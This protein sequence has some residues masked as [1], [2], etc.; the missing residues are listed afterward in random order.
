MVQ[1][2]T[3][4]IMHHGRCRD[5]D[6]YHINKLHGHYVNIGHDSLLD[7]MHNIGIKRT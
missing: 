1:C 3:A 6:E 2:S 4:H 5:T 7:S